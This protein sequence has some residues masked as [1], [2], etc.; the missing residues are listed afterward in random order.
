MLSRIGQAHSPPNHSAH[1]HLS[2]DS[3]HLFRICTLIKTASKA[4]TSPHSSVWS[5]S[6]EV[7]SLCYLH[8]T[9]SYLPARLLTFCVSSSLFS[10]APLLHL[11]QLLSPC[12]SF[13]YSSKEVC[14]VSRLPSTISCGLRNKVINSI[15]PRTVLL[16]VILTCHCHLLL[17]L[18]IKT[19]VIII[20][21]CLSL[22]P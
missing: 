7:D 13:L 10:C 14:A 16:P 11:L 9:L 5:H 18:L 8:D 3:T 4:H 17:L 19:P 1:P 22:L 2:T 6:Y 21:L 20:I 15:Y 12:G